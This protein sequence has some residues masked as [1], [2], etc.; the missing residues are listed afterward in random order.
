[1]TMF[2]K[3]DCL[4]D[5]TAHRLFIMIPSK[6]A[7]ERNTK[8]CAIKAPKRQK[9]PKDFALIIFFSFLFPTECRP[10]P[11]LLMMLRQEQR[12]GNKRQD[13]SSGNICLDSLV[14]IYR[15]ILTLKILTIVE[16]RWVWWIWVRHH[17][18]LSFFIIIIVIVDD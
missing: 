12:D 2:P 4:W 15:K 10:L 18:F 7:S 13:I 14:K 6:K 3:T 11:L 16:R 8:K 17:D 9:V 1:M 5:K